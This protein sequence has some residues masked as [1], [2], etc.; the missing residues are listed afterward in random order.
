MLI[1]KLKSNNERCRPSAVFYFT[2]LPT[3]SFYLGLIPALLFASKHNARKN[4]SL[5]LKR[6]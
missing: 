5:R 2:S 1:A 4:H 6:E 3:K